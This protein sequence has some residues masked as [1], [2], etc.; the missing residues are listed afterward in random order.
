MRF[1]TSKK[2][3]INDHI[4]ANLGYKSYPRTLGTEEGHDL[5]VDGPVP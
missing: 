5:M 4:K 2:L 1:S 3:H